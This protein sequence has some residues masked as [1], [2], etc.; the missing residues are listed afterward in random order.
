MWASPAPAT[1]APPAAS[2]RQTRVKA[3]GQPKLS[4]IA[5]PN[6][7]NTNCPNDPAAVPAPKRDAAPFRRQQLA[8]RRQHQIERAAGQAEAD[9]NA[10]A[11]IER[12][13]RG[14]IAH[15]DQAGGIQQRA[16]GDHA[17]GC[18]TGRRWRRRSAGRFPT[19]D[20]GS[21]ARGRT[22]RGPSQNSRLIGCMK[23]PR[24]ERGPNVSMP[25]RQPHTTIT[26][27][28]RQVVAG[29]GRRSPSVAAMQIPRGVGITKGCRQG[30]K[31]AGNRCSCK[32]MHRHGNPN[33]HLGKTSRR[34]AALQIAASRS[35]DLTIRTSGEA[36][37]R[38]AIFD[39]L[40]MRISQLPQASARTSCNAAG[41]FGSLTR[42]F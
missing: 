27:G 7:A 6:G 33:R 38:H 31:I 22:R 28:V 30:G 9:Q 42:S 35:D 19:T 39:L 29:A 12:Q 24:V 10:G 23:K 25:I 40:V 1:A 21:P 8:E 37:G 20:S 16:D 32:L 18:R 41:W 2:G 26:S 13:R 5:T 14:G 3:A 11:E 34:N 15:R 17:Q 36:R 4:S